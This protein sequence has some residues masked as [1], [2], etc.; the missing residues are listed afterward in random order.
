VAT[1]TQPKSPLNARAKAKPRA[2]KA[3]SIK[4]QASEKGG[5]V[6]LSGGNPRIAKADGDTRYLDLYEDDAFD[7]AQIVAWVKQ[8]AA[9]PG[10]LP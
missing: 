2:R 4:A 1:R 8:A 9:L 5:V 7:E 3:K 6:R 10:W